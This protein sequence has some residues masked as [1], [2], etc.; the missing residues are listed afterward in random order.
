M[1]TKRSASAAVQ[2][3]NVK[4]QTTTSSN[5]RNRLYWLLND[6]I[7]KKDGSLPSSITKVVSLLLRTF[8]KLKYGDS[9]NTNERTRVVTVGLRTVLHNDSLSEEVAEKLTFVSNYISEIRVT[10]AL[11]ANYLILK[12]HETRCSLPERDKV[13]YSTCLVLSCGGKPHDSTYTEHFKQFI[14]Q[15]G[16]TIPPP[17]EGIS[18]VRS[19]EAEKMAT[20]AQSFIDNH[21]KDRQISILKHHLKMN[22]PRVHMT[23]DSFDRKVYQFCEFIL[24]SDRH[25]EMDV[26]AVIKQKHISL[27]FPDQCFNTI[28]VMV[29]QVADFHVSGQDHLDHL[30]DLQQLYL[31]EDRNQY[32]SVIRQ[33]YAL[34]PKNSPDVN[35]TAR[36][37]FIKKHWT[38]SVPPKC[39]A[40]LPFADPHAVFIRVEKKAMS[41]MFGYKFDEVCCK[42]LYTPALNMKL[43][44]RFLF[45]TFMN[46]HNRVI[47]GGLNS[48]WILSRKQPIY[49]A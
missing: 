49:L 33:A 43:M 7:C 40:P 28:E 14:E 45:L 5:L 48:L 22:I 31:V 26:I 44:V 19:Y 1:P 3:R 25:T 20:A 13:F 35:K 24:S 32:E 30:I 11:F 38:L 17:P 2:Q 23:S 15:T 12:L 41:E 18:Q 16:I 42:L 10:A 37:L 39:M 8:A 9:V 27:G 34:H 4:K 6:S 21:F 36:S 47:L 46:L 29:S